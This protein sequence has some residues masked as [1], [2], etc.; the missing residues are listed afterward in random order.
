M[1][2]PAKR[3]TKQSKRERASHFA[4]TAPYRTTCGHCK[5]R[6]PPHRVCPYCGYYRGRPVA[7][8]VGRLERRAEKRT[9]R[10]GAK[11]HTHDQ[12]GK[13]EKKGDKQA[14]KET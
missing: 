11:P 13:D 1:G 3:R 2:L 14:E 5:R 9:R 8:V 10:T 12:D 6:I 7:S 4:L